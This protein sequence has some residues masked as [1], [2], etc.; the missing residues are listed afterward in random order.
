LVSLAEEPNEV[1]PVLTVNQ[2]IVLP[3]EVALMFKEAPLQILVAPDGVI[4][5]GTAGR[6]LTVTAKQLSLLQQPTLSKV[7]MQ[8]VFVEATV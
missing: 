3:V 6:A 1:P 4:A 8:G 7:L 2:S 5:V